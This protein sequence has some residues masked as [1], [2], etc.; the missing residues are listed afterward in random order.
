[1]MEKEN[2][3]TS[4]RVTSEEVSSIANCE[5]PISFFQMTVSF[6][7]RP[8]GERQSFFDGFFHDA[9][10]SVSHYQLKESSTGS[11]AGSDDPVS[12]ARAFAR[13]QGPITVLDS[14]QAQNVGIDVGIK[15]NREFN[16]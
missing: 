4:D 1:M 2:T 14:T 12:N 3:G 11:G 6:L 8:N 16:L 10:R 7:H 15:A 5:L 9:N 13:Q